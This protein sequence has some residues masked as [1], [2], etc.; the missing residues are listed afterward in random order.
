MGDGRQQRARHYHELAAELR[1]LTGEMRFQES[2]DQL[3]N[4]A[5]RFERLAKRMAA[6][7]EASSVDEAPGSRF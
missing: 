3:A 2:R 4:L 6:D 1:R 7:A 5:E